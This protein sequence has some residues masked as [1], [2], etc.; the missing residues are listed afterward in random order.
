MNDLFGMNPLDQVFCV[1]V[2]FLVCNRSHGVSRFGDNT[3]AVVLASAFVANLFRIKKPNL[4]GPLTSKE[5]PRKLFTVA[6]RTCT[7][8]RWGP[9][10][11]MILEEV[12]PRL[13]HVATDLGLRVCRLFSLI[14]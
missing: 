2:D 10:A 14:L 13:I 8:F 11:T 9:L 3:K 1:A 6:P 7:K 5:L 12:L 4:R